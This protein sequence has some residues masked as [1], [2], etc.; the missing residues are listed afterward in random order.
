MATLLTLKE[1]WDSGQNYITLAGFGSA[2]VIGYFAVSNCFP[3]IKS[4]FG[5]LTSFIY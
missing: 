3:L 2:A 5:Y 4:C 1:E